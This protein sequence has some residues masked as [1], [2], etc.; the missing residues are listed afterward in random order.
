MDIIYQEGL[1]AD[2]AQNPSLTL[3]YTLT[4]SQPSAGWDTP[5]ALIR[6]Y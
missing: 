4:M 3:L 6:R 5:G 1:D 2:V